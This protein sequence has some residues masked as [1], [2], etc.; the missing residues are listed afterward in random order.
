MRRTQVLHR[1]PPLFH[2]DI[3]WANVIQSAEDRSSW[4]I[5]DWEDAAAGPITVAAEHLD[6]NTHSP[7]VFVDNHGVKSTFGE[8]VCSSAKPA[9]SPATSP[10]S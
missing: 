10:V 6:P 7:R 2:R 5:I 1:H 4:F 9:G 3:R 8:L